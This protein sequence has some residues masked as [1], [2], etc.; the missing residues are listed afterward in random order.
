MS[1]KIRKFDSR[2]H[3]LLMW[4]LML[5]GQREVLCKE[6]FYHPDY[7]CG[8]NNGMLAHPHEC[9]GFD[10]IK[11]HLVYKL[12]QKGLDLIKKGIE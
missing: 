12:N 5:F 8:D 6:W 3:R 11:S 1:R 10:E 9:A 4:W 2:Q 7:N